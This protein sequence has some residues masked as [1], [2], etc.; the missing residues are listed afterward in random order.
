MKVNTVGVFNRPSFVLPSQI[1]CCTALAAFRES[2]VLFFFWP[3]QRLASADLGVCMDA[4]V[5]QLSS[6][7]VTGDRCTVEL[8]WYWRKKKKEKK[9]CFFGGFWTCQTVLLGV[10][11][12]REKMWGGGIFRRMLEVAALHGV[13]GRKGARAGLL[14]SEQDCP[15]WTHSA[16]GRDECWSLFLW[17]ARA[18][19]YP[20]SSLFSCIFSSPRVSFF[21]TACLFCVSGK[22][23]CCSVSLLW[24]GLMHKSR[25]QWTSKRLCFSF[26]PSVIPSYDTD[27]E[28][29][30]DEGDRGGVG[31]LERT[32]QEKPLWKSTAQP[33]STR[34]NVIWMLVSLCAFVSVCESVHKN[35][36]Y[37]WCSFQRK[38]KLWHRYPPW[39]EH[40]LFFGSN[41][42][43]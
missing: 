13:M 3:C 22:C 43:E 37:W 15:M 28:G 5:S 25:W 29:K 16:D 12:M 34:D 40:L 17:A 23:V 41:S 30:C 21:A 7:L 14:I 4:P 24:I 32:E 10:V 9:E 2:F 36:K 35:L 27:S 11:G 26:C 42:T 8:L 1:K 20:S 33:V 39:A 18:L 31:L 6:P 19:L 38:V